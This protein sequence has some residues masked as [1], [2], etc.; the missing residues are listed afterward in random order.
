MIPAALL[1]L[2]FSQDPGFQLPEGFEIVPA[3]APP[4]VER[5]LMACFDDRGRLYVAES[6]GL[7]L[8]DK[9]LLEKLPN[10]IALIEDTDGDGRFDKRTLFADRMT[11]PMGVLWHRGAVYSA[12]PPSLWK[13]EDTDGDGVADRRTELVTKFGFIGNA[14]DIHGPFLGP[15]GFI[16]WTDGRHGHT[17]RLPEG[18]T[19]QGKAA[20]LFRC[21]PDGGGVESVLG[22]GFDNPV[23][24]AFTEEGEMFFNANIMSPPGRPRVD[25]IFHGVEGGAYPYAHDVVREFK[26]TGALLPPL[27]EL[28]WVA[29]SGL[30]RCRG[31]EFR[32]RLFS[33]EFN[34]RRVRLHRVEREGATFRATNEPFLASGHPDFRPTDVLEDAD[35][36]LLVV[37][38]GGWFLKGCPNS[39]VSKPEVTGGL[40]RVR[41][42]GAV[43]VE[44]P[45]GVRV[46]WA[47]MKPVDLVRLLADAR[48]A[49][50]D[51]AAERL[52]AA[53]DP[54]PLIGAGTVAAA[55]VL[56]RIRPEEVRPLLKSG[57]PELRKVA[58]RALGLHRVPEIAGLTALLRDRSD[59]R[60]EAALALARLR[61]R[62]AVP[63]LL[64]ALRGESD[65]F[66]EHALIYALIE[67][68]DADATRKGPAG[69]GVA[70]AL[71]QMGALTK[72]DLLPLLDAGDPALLEIVARR[73]EWADAVVGRL[74]EWLEN[75]E[76]SEGRRE[77]VRLL[78][79]ALVKEAPIQALIARRL[80]GGHW[81][82]LMDAIAHA[83]PGKYAWDAG[84]EESV[85]IGSGGRQHM[86]IAAI[87]A[88]GTDTCDD[89]L[90]R[91]ARDENRP[92]DLRLAALRVLS[93]RRRT[94]DRVLFDWLIGRFREE[95]PSLERLTAARILSRAELGRDDLER[96]LP[97]IAKAEA[98][99]SGDLLQAFERGG[100]SDLGLKLVARLADV[101]SLGPA[102][103]RRVLARFPPDVLSAAQ[104]LLI[105]M[106]EGS[107]G[108]ARLEGLAAVLHGGDAR[109]GREVFQGQ[110]SA[111]A[112]C[113]AVKGK[114]GRVGPDLATI[115]SIRT[116]R[117]LLESIVLPSS[118]FSRGYEPYLAALKDGRVVG[119]FL[120][121]ETVDA[122]YLMTAE[123]SETRLARTAIEILKPGQV[124][125]MPE[126]L[127]AALTKPELADLIAYLLSLK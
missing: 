58:A 88:T 14:A 46:D 119:G 33:T 121:R 16:Y 127:D 1:L 6:A 95:V 100:D 94:L 66:L 19:M 85:T 117:D 96:L 77:G 51:R 113:H 62:E 82:V 10:R 56:A 32:D 36:S 91:L 79:Q 125:V 26:R 13:L 102:P 110:K 103:L 76:W 92:G 71:D 126:G 15:D 63:A 122:V 39:K 9:E 41:R 55:W 54:A 99:E 67:I 2:A 24:I 35:G 25:A 52:V 48:F 83:P 118:S 81:P 47:A 116:G 120:S 75:R 73:R 44:D 34:T 101:R 105:K 17:I 49:V 59:I 43:R 45:R 69:R 29:T 112:A 124:S 123:R 40:W 57:T 98:L 84:L 3:A 97:V 86:A 104:P 90:D 109:R 80:G 53:G 18:A 38:T 74:E 114:G 61:N 12:S 20:R 89:A 8:P 22:G 65:R 107:Q 72:E 5:P 11:M 111:C 70:I 68:G 64:E 21:R 4:V 23:E 60:R 93:V 108:L 50:R 30:V 87:E 31:P 106:E 115:G 27:V 7:N 78:L 28:G 42:R 37:D